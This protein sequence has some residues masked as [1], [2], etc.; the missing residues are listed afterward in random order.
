MEHGIE[1]YKH[2]LNKQSPRYHNIGISNH[3]G[4]TRMGWAWGPHQLPSMLLANHSWKV[5]MCPFPIEAQLT[6]RAHLNCPLGV[7]KNPLSRSGVSIV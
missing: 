1:K 6:A 7:G 5:V 4:E 3:N 2:T